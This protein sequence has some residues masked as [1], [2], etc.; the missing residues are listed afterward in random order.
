[1]RDSRIRFDQIPGRVLI[2][3]IL[4]VTLWEQE[5]IHP[6]RSTVLIL[7]I[8]EV[9]LWAHL[10]FRQHYRPESLNPYYT[11]SYSMSCWRRLTI[12]ANWRGLNPYY[13]GSYSMRH[14]I[15]EELKENTCLNPYYTGSYSMSQGVRNDRRGHEH[16]LILIILEVTLWV[17][18]M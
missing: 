17:W 5:K 12:C 11:G 16:V 9:T 2:L 7:I 3:I 4:E 8:L 1:M 15:F 14:V 18:Q 10:P 6:L 13:T